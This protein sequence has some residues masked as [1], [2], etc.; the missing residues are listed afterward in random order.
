MQAANTTELMCGHNPVYILQCLFIGSVDA[1][2]DHKKETRNRSV[3]GPAIQRNP[4]QQSW[5]KFCLLRHFQ[6][7][8]GVDDCTL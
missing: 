8:S 1:L 6:G 5:N 7:L 4:M 3:Q 2:S